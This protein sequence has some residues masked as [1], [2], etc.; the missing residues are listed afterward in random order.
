LPTPV[1]PASGQQSSA[2]AT[3]KSEVQELREKVEK[4]ERENQSAKDRAISDMRKEFEAKFAA[5]SGNPVVEAKTEAT[6]APTSPGTTGGAQAI[7]EA[8]ARLNEVGLS[9]SDPDVAALIGKVGGYSSRESFLLDV[10]RAIT[11]KAIKPQVSAAAAVAGAS[12]PPPPA[13]VQE[14]TQEYTQKVIANHGNK[15]AIQQLKAEYAK[16]GVPVDNVAFTIK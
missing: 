13:N 4:L 9:V 16:K 10:E 3:G 14:L 5:I 6:I 12:A 15:A 11:R 2:G 1:S 7:P 8:L